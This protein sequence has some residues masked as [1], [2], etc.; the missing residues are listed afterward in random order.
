MQ[1][2]QKM[3]I[4]GRNSGT[5]WQGTWVVRSPRRDTAARM[6]LS[7]MVLS[8]SPHTASSKLTMFCTTQHLEPLKVC[9]LP[10]RFCT[11]PSVAEQLWRTLPPR[12]SLCS[13]PLVGLR[14]RCSSPAQLGAV[15]RTTHPLLHSE[16]MLL[17]DRH[18][19]AGGCG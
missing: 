3:F 15:R 13:A 18:M 14:Q 1:G 6:A 9:Q 5:Q 2:L 8:F 17:T 10:V 11:A 4:V 12:S 16:H 7:S 19:P